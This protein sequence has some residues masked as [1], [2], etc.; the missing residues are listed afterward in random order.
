M[1]AMGD[2][3]QE[4]GG[5]YELYCIFMCEEVQYIP[6]NSRSSLDGLGCE[7]NIQCSRMI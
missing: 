4:K 6:H 1:I 5:I 3:L 2:Q 7:M